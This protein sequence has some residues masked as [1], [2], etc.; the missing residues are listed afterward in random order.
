M[1]MKMGNQALGSVT[2]TSYNAI[3]ALSALFVES[4]NGVSEMS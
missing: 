4:S 1:A 3:R 2:N